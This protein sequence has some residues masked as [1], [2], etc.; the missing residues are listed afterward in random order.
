MGPSGHYHGERRSANL[1]ASPP[2]VPSVM[3]KKGGRNFA[4]NRKS[5]NKLKNSHEDIFTKPEQPQAFLR[6]TSWPSWFK[7][8]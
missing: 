5:T 6:E 8:S 1:F 3:R 2:S 7:R 4:E